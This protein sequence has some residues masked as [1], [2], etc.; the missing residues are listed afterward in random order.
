VYPSTD[1]AIGLGFRF[2]VEVEGTIQGVF[3]ECAGLVATVAVEKW[4]EGGLNTYVHQFPGRTS[5]EN[6][7][8]KQ[9]V[10]AS[11]ELY[12]WFL[13]VAAGGRARK[14]ISVILADSEGKEVRRWEFTGAFPIKWEGPAL[15]VDSNEAAVESLEFAHAGLIPN[16][17]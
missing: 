2:M 7:K 10:F 3:T 11:T 5:F 6:L 8:L 1:T 14:P 13:E 4:E 15:K 9:A 12:D 17:I 16:G